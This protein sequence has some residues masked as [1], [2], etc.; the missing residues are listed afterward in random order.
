MN[1]ISK[2]NL[3]QF[4]SKELL[5]KIDHTVMNADYRISRQAV[6]D[7]WRLALLYE[8]GGVYL[9]ASTF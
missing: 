3:K 5:K 7:L 8:H 2:S 4:I 1:V 9:D 6:A